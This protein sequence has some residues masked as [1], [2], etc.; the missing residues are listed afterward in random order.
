MRTEAGPVAPPQ[1]PK[2][3]GKVEA[4]TIG[5]GHGLALAPLQFAGAVA[6]LVNGGTKVTPTLLARADDGGE[7]PRVVSLPPAP[8][9]GRSCAS[10]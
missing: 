9:C 1:L 3:W 7:R 4:I 10:T 6:A 8:G 2:H 5:Y